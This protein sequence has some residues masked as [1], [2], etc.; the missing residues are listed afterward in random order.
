M[1]YIVTYKNQIGNYIYHIN[2]CK[3][4]SKAL[5]EQKKSKLISTKIAVN[6]LARVDELVRDGFFTSRSDLNR[7]AVRDLLKKYN[8][9]KR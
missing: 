9:K 7:Y 3:C 4:M 8:N 5:T 1:I 6:E 2:Y